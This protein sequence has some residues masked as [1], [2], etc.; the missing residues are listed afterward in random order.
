[1][2]VSING[3]FY[4]ESVC[5]VRFGFSTF[6]FHKHVCGGIIWLLQ[7][8]SSLQT[9]KSTSVDFISIE[10]VFAW[11]IPCWANE[12]KE[13]AVTVRFGIYKVVQIWPGQ[14]GTCLLTISPG[15]IWTTLYIDKISNHE[16]FSQH[17]R[18]KARRTQRATSCGHASKQSW[19][20]DC[21]ACVKLL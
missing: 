3:K 18:K 4:L 12:W 6:Q 2:W 21:T 14:T 16:S 5:S 11:Y 8:V 1:M 17:D 15:H 20:I 10:P 19:G 9:T 13:V 7:I